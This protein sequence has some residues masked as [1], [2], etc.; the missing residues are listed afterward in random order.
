M[1]TKQNLTHLG[2]PVFIAR[3]IGVTPVITSVSGAAVG[4]AAQIAGDQFLTMITASNSGSGLALPQIGGDWGAN[5][6]ALLG[7]EFKIFN[8]LSGNIQ[9][10]CAN[11][12]NGSAVTLYINAVSA[13]GTT[14]ISLATGQMAVFYPITVSTYVGGKTSV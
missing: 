13:A 5:T 8:A 12:A 7:D 11:N 3:A 1:V 4:S 14:G 9:I 2:M 10:Y 6:G